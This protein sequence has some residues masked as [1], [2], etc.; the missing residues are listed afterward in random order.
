MA[1]LVKEGYVDHIL[2][3]HDICTKI[4]YKKYGGLGYTYI[5]EFFCLFY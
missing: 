5:H 2:L 3:S 4:D 1:H